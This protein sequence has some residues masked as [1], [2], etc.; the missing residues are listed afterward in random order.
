MIP[1]PFFCRFRDRFSFLTKQYILIF[2]D[3]ESCSTYCQNNGQ[4][5]I[6]PED[7]ISC[8]CTGTGYVGDSCHSKYY[9]SES[10]IKLD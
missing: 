4:C 8:N 3:P 10:E 2:S 6:H 1:L 5:M 9:K 7:G